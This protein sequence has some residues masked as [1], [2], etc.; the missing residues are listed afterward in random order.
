MSGSV[1]FVGISAALASGVEFVEALT[2]V[3]A[4][5]VAK[6][7]RDALEGAVAAS[8]ALAIMVAVIG[9]G[10]LQLVPLDVLRTVIGALLLI[11]GL[12]WLRKAILRYSGYKALHDEEATFRE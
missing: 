7:W 3:L 9:I 4:V 10:L 12:K 1:V 11:F 2:I 8:I 6:S 5:G